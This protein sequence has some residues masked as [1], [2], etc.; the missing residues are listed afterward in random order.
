MSKL[1]S[2]I[3]KL[4]EEYFEIINPINVLSTI[5]INPAIN[6]NFFIPILIIISEGEA[7][8]NS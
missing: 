4:K 7:P 8:T 1:K 5:K 2:T 6:N 3:K